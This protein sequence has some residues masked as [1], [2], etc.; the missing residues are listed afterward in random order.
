MTP[1]DARQ[2]DQIDP[3]TPFDICPEQQMNVKLA[4]PLHERIEELVRLAN[5][6]GA[7]ATR[8]DLI[9]A[10]VLAASSDPELLMAQVTRYR[11]GEAKDAAVSADRLDA[12]L[13]PQQRRPGRRRRDRR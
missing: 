10:L 6:A 5:T 12:V 11:K 9:A 8:K 3:L 4:A 7:A 2:S 1:P 13:R